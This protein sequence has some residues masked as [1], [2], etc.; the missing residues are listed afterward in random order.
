MNKST[1]ITY[2]AVTPTTAKS[3]PY[4]HTM[5]LIRN[6]HVFTCKTKCFPVSYIQSQKHV[7]Y[8]KTHRNYQKIRK[9]FHIENWHKYI[10]KKKK[11]I[12]TPSPCCLYLLVEN[13][14]EKSARL[15]DGSIWNKTNPFIKIDF[16]WKI[17]SF[18]KIH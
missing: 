9:I 11:E 13:S 2:R 18:M 1:S 15:I 17:Q 6:K 12:D 4:T 16:I 5:S 8:E 14:Q 3:P 10:T 7:S